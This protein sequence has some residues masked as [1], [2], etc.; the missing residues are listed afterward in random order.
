M[1]RG[2]RKTIITIIML[3]ICSFSKSQGVKM[4]GYHI[5]RYD[6]NEI[7]DVYQ[8]NRILID[9]RGRSYYFT[10]NVNDSVFINDTRQIQAKIRLTDFENKESYSFPPFSDRQL[11]YLPS[12]INVP[13]HDSADH[14]LFYMLDDD[15]THLY[16]IRHIKGD[17]IRLTF[18]KDSLDQRGISGLAIIWSYSFIWDEAFLPS[19]FDIYMV[20]NWDENCIEKDIP[21][22]FHPYLYVHRM[23]KKEKTDNK[24]GNTKDIVIGRDTYLVTGYKQLYR[25]VYLINVEKNGVTYRIISYWNGEKNEGFKKLKDG[26]RINVELHSPIRP[27]QQKYHCNISLYYRHN[28]YPCLYFNK[29]SDYDDFFLCDELNGIY[30]SKENVV[31]R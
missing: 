28:R 9:F 24:T 12:N 31:K 6:K 22:G 11:K 5:V 2:M 10:V 15:S 30:I 26:M 25:N 20:Y 1:Q 18:N 27:I 4:D 8:H 23:E 13:V 14:L 16:T 19:V 21:K 3:S 17:A 7:L 29:N